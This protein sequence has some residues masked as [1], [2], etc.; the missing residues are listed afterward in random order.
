MSKI[1]DPKR[2]SE[3]YGIPAAT[4]EKRG[5]FDP[6]LNADTLLFVD[7]LLLSSSIHPEMRSAYE[8]WRGH[9]E[10]LAKLLGE[11]QQVGDPV[12][13]AID[14]RLSF[15]EF[16]GTCLGYGSGS[17]RGTALAANVR[18]RIMATARRIVEL[19]IR[20]PEFF[21]VIPLIEEDVGPDSISDMTSHIISRSLA[22][23]TSRILGGTGVQ[24]ERFTID[25]AEFELPTNPF[26]SDRGKPLP[27]ILV[28]LDVLRDLPV[29]TDWSD[30]DHVVAHNEDL[31]ERISAAIGDIWEKKSRKEKDE[32]RRS[33]LS[34]REAFQALLDIIH[35]LNREAYDFNRD[36]AGR[37]KWLEV[38]RSI[39]NEFPFPLTL[40]KQDVAGLKE[41]IEKIIEH[42]KYLVENQ[43]V[44]KFLYVDGKP[45]HEHFGQKIFFVTADAYCRTSNV[46]IT[47]EA[48]SGS[49]P[50]DFKF[51]KGYGTRAVV[52]LKLSRNTNLRNGYTKQLEAYKKGER[53]EVGYYVVLDLGGASKQ[54]DDVLRLETVARNEGSPH[55]QVIVIDA[56][57]KSSASKR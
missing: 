25:G 16:K 38:G 11:V 1:V 27:V 52:E 35:S 46:D 39:A 8:V 48:N 36:P 33:A 4:I 40:K 47:P 5:A 29:A 10:K 30:I 20:D 6:I 49:G 32:L 19:G 53:T 31:R 50:V 17:I 43:G 56:A 7:P 9:F 34:S 2:F 23:F 37:Y 22:A 41:V 45:L 44:W 42:F 18:H 3:I 55:S 57:P 51:S 21:T 13:R 12:W 26:E 15:R 28:P 54:L 14:R 24:T